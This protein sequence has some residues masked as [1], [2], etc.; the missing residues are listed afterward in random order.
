MSDLDRDTNKLFEDFLSLLERYLIIAWNGL[1]HLL[2][3]V[4]LMPVFRNR[5]K[6]LAALIVFMCLITSPIALFWLVLGLVALN[7]Q[8]DM[9]RDYVIDKQRAGKQLDLVNIACAEKDFEKFQSVSVSEIEKLSGKSMDHLPDAVKDFHCL[10]SLQAALMAARLHYISEKMRDQFSLDQL[11]RIGCSKKSAMQIL[12][13][14]KAANSISKSGSS[15]HVDG[16]AAFRDW[17]IKE[18]QECLKEN[19]R[20]AYEGWLRQ[21]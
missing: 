12:C 21:A 2:V 11:C 6:A 17:K 7:N 13:K 10:Y 19:I 16:G 3:G 5:P 15:S 8:S 20:N 4:Q 9:D 14:A 18:D 1:M